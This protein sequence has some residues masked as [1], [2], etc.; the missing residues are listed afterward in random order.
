MGD[1]RTG[2]GGGE[3]TV[4]SGAVTAF[5]S[6]TAV[7]GVLETDG[8]VD[9]RTCFPPSVANRAAPDDSCLAMAVAAA[10]S[11]PWTISCPF[12]MVTLFCPSAWIPTTMFLFGVT[13][14]WGGALAGA[15]DVLGFTIN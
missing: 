7:A 3:E 12:L 1:L 15:G 13:G 9:S 2:A 14:G 4:E 10:W 8:D 5:W 11:G 6:A